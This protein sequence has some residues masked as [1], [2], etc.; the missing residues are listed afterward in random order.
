MT[1]LTMTDRPCQQTGLTTVLKSWKH[2]HPLHRNK[3]PW[4]AF[5]R[6]GDV[7]DARVILFPHTGNVPF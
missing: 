4:N 1:V 5:S 7:R 6:D 3:K 2:V